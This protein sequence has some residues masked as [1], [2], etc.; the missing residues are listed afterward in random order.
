M[1]SRFFAFPIL[2]ST[3]GKS[4]KF[5]FIGWNPVFPGV[6]MYSSR[7][8]MDVSLGTGTGG[9]PR[10]FLEAFIPQTIPV[11]ADSTYPSTPVICPAKKTFGR[12]LRERSL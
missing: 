4:P 12:D 6:E 9:S 10:V 5:M 1:I 8:P 7:E 3:L 2:P 11:A